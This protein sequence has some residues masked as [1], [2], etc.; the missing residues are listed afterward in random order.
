MP[1][2]VEKVHS[3]PLPISREGESADELSSSAE[4]SMASDCS[5]LKAIKE[6]FSLYKEKIKGKS[7]VDALKN[8]SLIEDSELEDPNNHLFAHLHMGARAKSTGFEGL[9]PYT[10]VNWSKLL[11][12]EMTKGTFQ[13]QLLDVPKK[14][15]VLESI[16]QLLDTS[17]NIGN[18]WSW[19]ES[20]LSTRIKSH[21]KEIAVKIQ[22]LPPGQ[23]F[24]MPGGYAASPFGHAMYY[25]F[26][27]EPDNSFTI[28]LYNAGEG[29]DKWQATTENGLAAQVNP[30]VVFSGVQEEEL[31]FTATGE[32]KAGIFQSLLDLQ[33]LPRCLP[34]ESRFRFKI[35]DVWKAFL[36]IQHRLKEGTN[37]NSY[38]MTLQRSG[39][40]AQKSLNACL[41]DLFQDPVEFKAFSLNSALVSL[42]NF[43]HA[44]QKNLDQL[45][46]EM[47]KVRFQIKEAANNFIQRLEKIAKGKKSAYPSLSLEQQTQYLA[48]CLDLI[49]RMECAENLAND[50]HKKEPFSVNTLLVGEKDR[51]AALEALAARIAS[52]PPHVSV[53]ITTDVKP[54]YEGISPADVLTLFETLWFNTSQPS[55]IENLLNA[56][57]VPGRYPDDPFWSRV[58][59]IRQE[60]LACIS[61]LFHHYIEESTKSTPLS[62]PSQ[63]QAAL[64]FLAIMHQ[65][66]FRYD[67][68][69]GQNLLDELCLDVS[70][71]EDLYKKDHN[72]IPDDPECW[73]RF[74]KL[75]AYF[76]T[77]NKSKKEIF[78][79]TKN[80][81]VKS[82]AFNPELTLYVSLLDK[83]PEYREWAKQKYLNL[84]QKQYS[85]LELSNLELLALCSLW[86]FEEKCAQ[87]WIQHFKNT[88]NSHI[89][90]IR[91]MMIDAYMGLGVGNP[92]EKRREETWIQLDPFSGS[93]S[94]RSCG[95]KIGAR[96]KLG[97]H[98]LKGGKESLPEAILDEL[99]KPYLISYLEEQSGKKKE[100]SEGAHLQSLQHLSEEEKSLAQLAGALAE[101]DASI[102]SL[103]YQLL[104]NPSLPESPVAEA[105][106]RHILYRPHFPRGQS[107]AYIPLYEQL[108]TNGSLLL[109]LFQKLIEKGVQIH[110]TAQTRTN[111]N[112]PLTLYY[113]RL[114]Q[115]I[116]QAYQYFHGELPSI[117]L[118][119]EKLL[120]SLEATAEIE[121]SLSKHLPMIYLHRLNELL[122]A[123][124]HPDTKREEDW[125]EIYSEWIS[126]SCLGSLE[127]SNDVDENLL[128]R[129]REKMEEEQT[130]FLKFIRSNPGAEITILDR[131]TQTLS[132]R[133]PQVSEELQQTGSS[134]ASSLQTFLSH[135][136]T[137]FTKAQ[138]TAWQALGQDSLTFEKQLSGGKKLT[139]NLSTGAITTDRGLLSMEKIDGEDRDF[140]TV[141]GKRKIKAIGFGGIAQFI[142]P[143]YGKCCIQNNGQ[144]QRKIGKHWFTFIPQEVIKNDDFQLPKAL[145]KGFCH[146]IGQ[147]PATKKQILFI[148]S[149]KSG[150]DRYFVDD[151]GRLSA[152]PKKNEESIERISDGTESLISHFEDPSYVLCWVKNGVER[153]RLEF[154]RYRTEE[155]KILSFTAKD[156]RFVYDH[157]PN[158]SLDIGALNLYAG[159]FLNF[160]P[161][162]HK[163]GKKKKVLIPNQ[164]IKSEGF[165]ETASVVLEEQDSINRGSQN[166]K[167]SYFEYQVE[168]ANL[169]AE[170]PEGWFMLVQL[171]LGQK[172][173]LQAAACLEKVN[174]SDELTTKGK[175]L[176]QKILASG[177]EIQDYSP[178]ALAIR[179]RAY[180]LLKKLDPFTPGYGILKIINENGVVHRHIEEVYKSYLEG[181]S[182]VINPLRLTAKMEAEL[183]EQ[184]NTRSF[185]ARLAFLHEGQYGQLH[186][187]FLKEKPDTFSSKRHLVQ[188]DLNDYPADPDD[189]TSP[190]WPHYNRVLNSLG[191]KPFRYYSSNFL[192]DYAFLKNGSEEER[193]EFIYRLLWS[194]FSPEEANRLPPSC[195]TIMK[196]VCTY[197]QLVPEPISLTAPPNQKMEWFAS[198]IKVMKEKSKNSSLLSPN[199]FRSKKY[200]PSKEII[201]ENLP[202][203]VIE[204][205]QLTTTALPSSPLAD[206]DKIKTPLDTALKHLGDA[207]CKEANLPPA[208]EASMTFEIKSEDLT[209]EEI[210]FLAIIEEEI[211]AFN[212][213]L[214]R[215][216]ERLEE[217]ASFCVTEGKEEELIKSLKNVEQ[218]AATNCMKLEQEALSLARAF[219]LDEKEKLKCSLKL[220]GYKAKEISMMDLARASIWGSVEEYQK[221]SPNLNA[222]EIK[223]LHRKVLKYMVSKTSLDQIKRALR[224]L[225]EIN[226]NQA[227]SLAKR[228]ALLV[229]AAEA[230]RHEREYRPE[231]NL[232]ALYFEYASGLRLRKSQALL[233]RNLIKQLFKKGSLSEVGIVFQMIQ[234]GGK[235]SVILSRLMELLAEKGYLTILVSHHSQMSS[236]HGNMK[237]FQRNRF[238]K[239]VISLD[240]SASE[241]NQLQ[242]LQQIEKTLKEVQKSKDTLVVSSSFLQSLQL[243]L[244]KL[245]L[246]RKQLESQ[247]E[248]KSLDAKIAAL[249]RI[250]RHIK[251]EGVGLFDEV[252]LI[253]DIFQRMN[254]PT[255]NRSFLPQERILLVK[256]IFQIL[257]EPAI[258]Q[259]LSLSKNQQQD[260]VEQDFWEQ[261]VPRM[262]KKLIKRAKSLKLSKNE[263]LASFTRYL[264]NAIPKK[265]EKMARG[266]IDA[267]LEELSDPEKE[268]FAFL[269]YLH[270]TL[271]DSSEVDR[272]EAAELIALARG[273]MFKILPSTLRK[274]HGRDYGHDPKNPEKI[275]P[276]LAVGVPAE[277]EFGHVYELLC[278]LFQ[279]ALNA[280]IPEQAI[281]KWA[282]VMTEIANRYV[283]QGENFDETTEAEQFYALTGIPL[284]DAHKEDA[285]KKAAEK[286]NQDQQ[287]KVAFQAE[288]AF[289]CVSYFSSFLSNT[290]LA[291][292]DQL[293]LPLGDSANVDN[294]N[295]YNPKISRL[296]RDRGAEGKI[297][298]TLL[299]RY[300]D[301]KKEVP[302]IEAEQLETFLENCFSNKDLSNLHL[303]VDGNGLLKKFKSKEVALAIL[304]Y[305]KKV[306]QN[307]KIRGVVFYSKHEDK[308]GF[309]LLKA[310]SSTPIFLANTTKEEIE[311]HGI[312]IK[313]LFFSL[314]ELRAT[315][316]DL[317]MPEDAKGIGTVG[318][319]NLRHIGQMVMR[320]RNLFAGQEIDLVMA[321]SLEKNLIG[322]SRAL[323]KL[324]LTALKNQAIKKSEETF[325]SFK[326]QIPNIYRSLLMEAIAK[327]TPEK[328]APMAEVFLPFYECTFQDSPFDHF[329]YLEE[330]ETPFEIFNEIA[331]QQ[332]ALFEKCLQNS[333][334]LLPEEFVADIR[335]TALKKFEE[336]MERAERLPELRR[337]FPKAPSDQLGMQLKI[338]LE[339]SLEQEN[340]LQISLELNE[341]EKSYQ[342]TQDEGLF[343]E[344]PWNFNRV[345]P[346][347]PFQLGPE[348]CTVSDLLKDCDSN[349]SWIEKR[350]LYRADYSS[351]LPSNLKM[352]ENLRFTL[353]GTELPLFH[354][355]QKPGEKVLIR[356][357]EDGTIEGIMLSQ[358][359]FVCWSQNGKTPKGIW[360]MNA[361][362]DLLLPSKDPLPEKEEV[363]FWTELEETLW[364]V[365]FFN[366]NVAYL[367]KEAL[368]SQTLLEN[369]KGLMRRFL[370]NKTASMPDQRKLLVESTLFFDSQ[371]IGNAR[372]AKEKQ[373]RERVAM[374]EE[375]ELKTLPPEM[376]R[377]VPNE[378][379][380][381][382]TNPAQ[383]RRL[384]PIQIN[385]IAPECVNALSPYQIPYLQAPELIRSLMQPE[386]IKRVAPD[387]ALHLL[388]DQLSHHA[389]GI[390]Q[391]RKRKKIQA[392]RDKELIE[393]LEPH[394]MEHLLPEQVPYIKLDC[395][396]SLRKSEQIQ[397]LKG[398][399]QINAIDASG[400]KE[401][402]SEQI[403]Q[404]R[405]P[406]L[407]RQLTKD[408]IKNLHPLAIP[409]LDVMTQLG[410]LNPE[411][412][413]HIS[414]QQHKILM[415]QTKIPEV[416]KPL[417]NRMHSDNLTAYRRM[418]EK[419]GKLPK[420]S[421]PHPG[422]WI[423][424]LEMVENL[425]EEDFQKIT[426]LAFYRQKQSDELL[427]IPKELFRCKELRKL[428]LSGY[429]LS[430]LDKGENELDCPFMETL[431]L[432]RGGLK[433]LPPCIRKM[434]HL[435]HLEIQKQFIKTIPLWIGELKNLV[436]LDLWKNQLKELPEEIGNLVNL[437]ELLLDS[438]QLTHLPDS[439]GKLTKV[440]KL[441]ISH[442]QLNSLPDSIGEMQ[443]L[444]MLLAP[445]NQLEALPASIAA[446]PELTTLSIFQNRLTQLPVEFEEMKSLEN[447]I[448]GMNPLKEFPL[449][450]LKMQKLDG[451][452]MDAC[453]LE[454]IPEEISQLENLSVLRLSAN[455][456]KQL[457][458]GIGALE[459]LWLLSLQGTPL[460]SL[461]DCFAKLQNMR[462]VNLD[463]T[464]IAELPSTLLTL[465][466]DVVI[467]LGGSWVSPDSP[468]VEAMKEKKI[469][470]DFSKQIAYSDINY[471]YRELARVPIWMLEGKSSPEGTVEIESKSLEELVSANK[472]FEILQLIK[473]GFSPN[474]M[475][476][477]GKTLFEWA[478]QNKDEVLVKECIAKGTNFENGE[479]KKSLFTLLCRSFPNYPD[480]ILEALDKK[481]VKNL[482]I[483]ETNA[484]MK[485]ISKEQDFSD[486]FRLF[487]KLK[488]SL[489]DAIPKKD[490]VESP[491]T[492]SNGLWMSFNQAVTACFDQLHLAALEISK[493]VTSYFRKLFSLPKTVSA[494]EVGF[495]VY[496][497]EKDLLKERR[498]I[499]AELDKFAKGTWG[500][501]EYQ[502]L[503]MKKRKELLKWAR[504]FGSPHVVANFLLATAKKE[505]KVNA[506]QAIANLFLDKSWVISESNEIKQS[507]ALEEDALFGMRP[508][509][510]SSLISEG[511]R[512][513][514]NSPSLDLPDWVKEPLQS[515]LLVAM[516]RATAWEKMAAEK[517]GI[518]SVVQEVLGLIGSLPAQKTVLVPVGSP[519]HNFLVQVKRGEGDTFDLKVVNTGLGLSH[520]AR[521]NEKRYF[522][523]FRLFQKIPQKSLLKKKVWKEL[524]MQ[525]LIPA[526]NLDKHYHL[527]SKL[528]KGGTEA[529]PS[530]ERLDYST[531][532]LQGTCAASPW[533]SWLRH[534]I[535]AMGTDTKEGRHFTY[536]LSRLLKNE[537]RRSI[538]QIVE[539]GS[540]AEKIQREAESKIEKHAALSRL[541]NTA[542]ERKLFNKTMQNLKK[543]LEKLLPEREV[544]KI[545]GDL[546]RD[547]VDYQNTGSRWHQLREASKVVAEELLKLR[548]KKRREFFN[549]FQLEITNL[550]HKSYIYYS[551]LEFESSEEHLRKLFEDAEKNKEW[552]IIG[553]TLGRLALDH[554]MAPL[555][556]KLARQWLKLS[557]EAKVKI[558][559]EN[560]RAVAAAEILNHF[561]WYVGQGRGQEKTI[562]ELAVHFRKAGC[563]AQAERFWM[564]QRKYDPN[565]LLELIESGDIEH[566]DLELI[567]HYLSDM[568]ALT[569]HIYA[570]RKDFH[571][572]G[573]QRVVEGL[574][575]KAL[576]LDDKEYSGLKMV[577]E[578][579]YASGFDHLAEA[580][581]KKVLT[582]LKKKPFPNWHNGNMHSVSF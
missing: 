28:V 268:D 195:D 395:V 273:I 168:N 245:L 551:L 263:H 117:A 254:F 506:T 236:I 66:T 327:C 171:F 193:K 525:H 405:N 200:D 537:A 252:D 35:E 373:M 270:G 569:S 445:N 359:D 501:K 467:Q 212:K 132:Q 244:L 104:Q 146:W 562:R 53:S 163:E 325:R 410:H 364:Y 226:S 303:L 170:S 561:F 310:G 101:P 312:E 38:F 11:L 321:S 233:F 215:G 152:F 16:S 513:A 340:Q 539:K 333:P 99:S 67:K 173:Y 481:G 350:G 403:K 406:Q 250:N 120:E 24:F 442:N 322:N 31:F 44:Q 274:S 108:K 376:A 390:K 463:Y 331:D 54:A 229:S 464:R 380:A 188:D 324:I 167:F 508:H 548:G 142:D 3:T 509:I 500:Q 305:F 549:Q 131:V 580:I 328:A 427:E 315:G 69:N 361:E 353:A 444:K 14:E 137:V 451:L 546:S 530:K 475:L 448:I 205:K 473:S 288:L 77:Q 264:T 130:V 385:W 291:L 415:E 138:H 367:I 198:L 466:K 235:S 145:R 526:N 568:N 80:R 211:T 113:V 155:G 29:A 118:Y 388:E 279:S 30:F 547:F 370:L 474:T 522:Q 59:P 454:T 232:Q 556:I 45:S 111:S 401:L 521:F 302:S 25:R 46:P 460:T 428:S 297:V 480:L 19:D 114:G 343:Q 197:P 125:E 439:I 149:Q 262:A 88:Q 60:H 488:A 319:D 109:T 208:F 107:T 220:A 234:G 477:G 169:V 347:E 311:K 51:Q 122:L 295:S 489:N 246:E 86:E 7:L 249:Q 187:R 217:E 363:A 181:L 409:H 33:V 87:V 392:I 247:E 180:W 534:E 307:N 61:R 329:G 543:M 36:P 179:L 240:Y 557:E 476:A 579:L 207:F 518:E 420:E 452:D 400:V 166:K 266:I 191:N 306:D 512:K 119:P 129:V 553:S 313:N 492:L 23:S 419:A 172:N 153:T 578:R 574:I 10:A 504:L 372:L 382:L 41:L 309:A 22:R 92:Q 437:E 62:R 565:R 260:F 223:A 6:D 566:G 483:P 103:L 356:R 287:L 332:S 407:I 133:F 139:L 417:W 573:V 73:N 189:I 576:V 79:Y 334:E 2:L 164:T 50:G 430:P 206:G 281:Q 219:P 516:E 447:L 218:V 377:F 127:L 192:Q 389:M 564:E 434:T 379:V 485:M 76:R 78:C 158:Y 511:L 484:L 272:K 275:I 502:Q 222:N 140:Q 56:L 243:Q 398:R 269:Q 267:K 472:R 141:F 18:I 438:N 507:D 383:I 414:K 71:F 175:I 517:D 265:I 159:N 433:Q 48:T 49:E 457:P 292:V 378:K 116:S 148:S 96:E 90:A 176:I 255:A 105:L 144:I 298:A 462:Y 357:K 227:I 124:T 491:S 63:F 203:P 204:K 335:K 426:E 374:M 230:I 351:C 468:Q 478:L 27:R 386:L 469:K 424:L 493:A 338:M 228:Q 422:D 85:T 577:A 58:G 165:S 286:I 510:A 542:G 143:F 399:S 128:R 532:Q 540:V 495:R 413:K 514:L 323:S 81:C 301:G 431:G 280:P 523:T 498:E 135:L 418:L 503:P 185:R 224:P 391:L 136:S 123:K 345:D 314:D 190:D 283:Q 83:N 550:A 238:E 446:I 397:A 293:L 199:Q 341:E 4:R 239:N 461:P 134:S 368:L 194:P 459:N 52:N 318:T 365:N 98:F 360:V 449:P 213:E 91:Q 339:N 524:L 527:I 533:W 201:F 289:R 499:E 39:T 9:N 271:K 554:K 536:G 64:S 425:T 582:V 429:D 221:L 519:D 282:K 225:E 253:L 375:E 529:A 12:S 531:A 358:R 241:L 285:I 82:P 482:T 256:E 490:L 17:E 278:Y 13:N 186:K 21:A 456:I 470:V 34:L 465:P 337:L 432:T 178:N 505:G 320:L 177:S 371:G 37:Y 110:F 154:T 567:A 237:K 541:L 421:T 346:W 563:A 115:E 354:R 196:F 408:Q 544:V 455:P 42:V 216:K 300:E 571:H 479:Q 381:L 344:I 436:H 538:L 20:S 560:A 89:P 458:L 75:L 290:P 497:M 161:L 15:L 94:I 68:E 26:T 441:L 150:K 121:E 316:S 443:Q 435:T 183:I 261:V 157:D 74:Q 57:P 214:K 396:S 209:K 97:D 47:S 486:R 528:A 552:A 570:L 160:L 342:L 535:T 202:I 43:Y 126:L 284:A 453:A 520:H 5:G 555:A 581:E 471:P 308:E 393:Q 394:Q 40:C 248:I 100:M 317:P 93:F 251:E 257:S 336:L 496:L 102:T 65:L 349:G 32:V 1:K 352:T 416:L 8:D 515:D 174:L 545:F 72:L 299:K 330:E 369:S 70:P 355:L 259:C 184:L 112:I 182:N 440:K 294:A 362:G 559:E 242:I 147:D 494:K 387:Q 106:I 258:D 162:I 423:Y 558:P 304:D 402:S 326:E 366:G 348:V 450:I 231:E 411:Q 277:T 296:L 95:R 55:E 84:M 487:E 575:D 156:G 572:A 384:L 412:Y 151:K 210:P 276:Y 404:L